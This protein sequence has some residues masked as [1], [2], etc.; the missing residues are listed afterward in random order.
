MLGSCDLWPL[1][2]CFIIDGVSNQ[3]L[4]VFLLR[5]PFSAGLMR[6]WCSDV[7]VLAV[8]LYTYRQIVCCLRSESRW[9]CIKHREGKDLARITENRVLKRQIQS[10]FMKMKH[11]VTLERGFNGQADRTGALRNIKVRDAFVVTIMQRE[12]QQPRRRTGRA[13]SVSAWVKRSSAFEATHTQC[14]LSW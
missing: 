3:R 7:H 11:V 2:L 5:F 6:R 4:V 1:V 8:R 10:D 12:N 9:R 14:L 13:L